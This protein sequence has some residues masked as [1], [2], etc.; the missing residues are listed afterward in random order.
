MLACATN[1]WGLG[2]CG[3]NFGGDWGEEGKGQLSVDF[4]CIFKYQ[5]GGIM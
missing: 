1:A 4:L 3:G 5:L 2:W